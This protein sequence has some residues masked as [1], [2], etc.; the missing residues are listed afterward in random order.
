MEILSHTNIKNKLS[1]RSFFD[2]KINNQRLNSIIILDEDPVEQV[3]ELFDKIVADETLQM[4]HY[5]VRNLLSIAETIDPNIVINLIV[6]AIDKKNQSIKETIIDENGDFHTINLGMYI[7]IWKSYRQFTGNIYKFAKKYQDYLVNR[8]IMIGKISH[9]ILNIVQ[10]SM[11]YNNIINSNENSN[12]LATVSNDLR[13]VNKNNIDQLIGY[14]DSIRLFITMSDFITINK[15]NLINIIK[16]IM[17]QN[18]II[19][20]MCAKLHELLIDLNNNQTSD[21]N[22]TENIINSETKY[23]KKIYKITTILATYVEKKKLLLFYSKFMQTR[24]INF[25]YNNHEMEIELIRRISGTIEREDA[26]K[27]VNAISNIINCKNAN[28]IIQAANIKIKS[29]EY[30][31]LGEIKTKILTPIIL[32]KNSWKIYNT[33]KLIPNYP[34]EMKCYLDVISKSYHAIYD[35]KYAIDWQP[36][37]GSAQF[38]AILGSRKVNITCNILQAIALMSFNKKKIMTVKDFVTDVMINY[39]LS[40]KIFESLEEAN[41]II[42]LQSDNKNSIYTI[43]NNSY[44]GNNILDIRKMFVDTFETEQKNGNK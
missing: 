35:G 11:F 20:I 42:S 22:K 21:D 34:L 33:C 13:E 1:E 19:N 18:N 31:Y 36:T 8:D 5:M 14:I 7:Q 41:I 12:I 17:N 27:L 29:D 28:K 23:I 6:S 30:K 40:E 43:N 38:E 24:I 44:Y 32:N 16:T 9:D 3:R 2:L 10:I 39:E 15:E 26:Q 25:K 37:L 4:N